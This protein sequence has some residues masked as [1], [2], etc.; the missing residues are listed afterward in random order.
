DESQ[1]VLRWEIDNARSLN[2]AIVESR[3]FH[4][5]G[6]E[7]KASIRPNVSNQGWV[8]LV[9]SCQKN[10]RRGWKC[11]TKV[12]FMIQRTGYG[13]FSRKEEQVGFHET[14]RV[15]RFS[16]ILKWSSL[17]DPSYIFVVNNKLIIKFLINIENAEDGESTGPTPD[18]LAKLCSPREDNNVTLFIGD[19]KLRVSKDY[20]AMHS[21]VFE[22]MF[23]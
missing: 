14:Q 8:D 3:T 23:Y 18:D 2:P 4:K 12:Q 21:P 19:K 9:L 13:S 1:V 6:F 15:A 20:L 7:W 22:A 11:D 5:G 10:K 16:K 17:K